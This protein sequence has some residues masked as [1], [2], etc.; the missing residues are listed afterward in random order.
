MTAAACS[1]YEMI[2]PSLLQRY[3]CVR[4]RTRAQ[5][6]CC[7]G[8]MGGRVLRCAPP[9]G[10]RGRSARDSLAS[11]A[12]HSFTPP[13]PPSILPER[14]Y[15]TRF[16]RALTR[17]VTFRPA[18]FSHWP[19][20]RARVISGFALARAFPSPDGDVDDDRRHY[21]RRMR[22]ARSRA[23]LCTHVA[24][25]SRPLLP[26]RLPLPPAC[27]SFVVARC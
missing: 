23:C 5:A 21:L 13:P 27:T 3:I 10:A 11:P 17:T 12:G 6:S 14:I 8:K 7:G 2:T 4:A 24:H 25:T 16:L 1:T 9:L 20:S 26:R 18:S 22:R 15:G 19:I